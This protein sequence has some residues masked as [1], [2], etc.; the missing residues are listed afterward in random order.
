MDITLN[1]RPESF[2][3]EKLTISEILKLKNYSFKMMVVRINGRLIKKPEYN[4]ADVVDGDDVQI[5]H[6]ISGG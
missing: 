3:Y 6:L 1:N 4:L 2:D 5:L